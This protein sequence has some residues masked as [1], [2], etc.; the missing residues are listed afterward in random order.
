MSLPGAG[1]AETNK[2]REPIAPFD[3]HRPTYTEKQTDKQTV[4]VC[5][6]HSLCLSVS[7]SLRLTKTDRETQTFTQTERR[8]DT[9]RDA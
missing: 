3:I 1:T 7:V 2:K 8:T 6:S 4:S 9:D 5:L